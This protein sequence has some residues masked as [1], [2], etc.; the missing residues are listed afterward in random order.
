MIV[1]S[2]GCALFGYGVSVLLGFFIQ[3]FKQGIDA[4]QQTGAAPVAVQDVA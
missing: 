2:G 1:Y 4:V 3:L